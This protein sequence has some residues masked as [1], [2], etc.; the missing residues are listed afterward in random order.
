MYKTFLGIITIIWLIDIMN[1]D[2][3][4]NGIHVAEFLDNTIPLNFWFW[5]L[6]WLWTPNQYMTIN[7]NYTK[8]I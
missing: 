3:L 7:R 6:F 5:F 2:F 4:F 1:I 8:E